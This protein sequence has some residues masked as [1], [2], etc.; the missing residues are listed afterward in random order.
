MEQQEFGEG[1]SFRHGVDTPAGTDSNYWALA[2]G[3]GPWSSLEFPGV[4]WSSILSVLPIYYFWTDVKLYT[5]VN[6]GSLL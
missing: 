6:K 3:T 5:R 2:T 4:P 1:G